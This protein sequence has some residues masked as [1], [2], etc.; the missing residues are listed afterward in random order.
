MGIL[1]F[2]QDKN[3]VPT[4]TQTPENVSSTTDGESKRFGVTLQLNSP[5]NDDIHAF[6]AKGYFSF[7]KV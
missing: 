3:E 2:G 6:G 4:I 7:V 5:S 1:V